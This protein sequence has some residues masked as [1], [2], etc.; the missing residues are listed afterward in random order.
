MTS[1]E[2]G[3]GLW[4]QLESFMVSPRTDPVR[5]SHVISGL[6]STRSSNDILNDVVIWGNKRAYLGLTTVP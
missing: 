3:G 6:T 1:A 2:G 5:G 4:S